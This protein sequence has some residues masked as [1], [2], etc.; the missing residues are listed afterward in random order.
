M[1]SFA[2]EIAEATRLLARFNANLRAAS[3][4]GAGGGGSG[5]SAAGL[6]GGLAGGRGFLAAAG[7]A[8]IAL[9]GA[10]AATDA[11]AAGARF[12]TP[13]AS[14]YAATGS[15][16]ALASGVTQAVLRTIQSTDVGALGLGLSGISA[17]MDTNQRAG[18]D[19]LSTTED[20]ARIG[21]DVGDKGRRQLFDVAQDQQK[22]VTE[23]RAKVAAIAG[24]AAELNDAKP[25]GGGAGFDAIVGVLERIEMQLATGERGGRR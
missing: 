8:G 14:A 18:A 5:G 24:S 16:Q 7:P 11:V 17:A 23:E 3:G 9:A 13:A 12:L 25:K 21:V 19:V 22:R 4:G 2:Q 15:S 20:L 10:G 6:V 1:A